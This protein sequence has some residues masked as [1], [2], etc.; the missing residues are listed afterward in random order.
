MGIRQFLTRPP[1]RAITQKTPCP[2]SNR[3]NFMGQ[4]TLGKLKSKELTGSSKSPQNSKYYPGGLTRDFFARNT[5]ELCKIFFLTLLLLDTKYSISNIKTSA[6]NLTLTAL[7]P[8][9]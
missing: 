9:M 7:Q 8:P 6:Q 3:R 2:V 1:L 4:W 5:E